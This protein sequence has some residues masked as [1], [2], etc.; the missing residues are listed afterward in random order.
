MRDVT[1]YAEHVFLHPVGSVGHVVH[2]GAYGLQNVYA[3]FLMMGWDR[4]GFPKK[5]VE[6]RYTELVI[7]H[8][9]RSTSHVAHSGALGAQNVDAQFF[10]LGWTSTYSTKSMRDT[11]R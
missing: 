1:R 5:R 4:C 10:M 2:S 7:W 6:T 9:V 8:P 3:L 11:L